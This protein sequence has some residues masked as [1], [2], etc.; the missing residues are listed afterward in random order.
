MVVIAVFSLRGRIPSLSDIGAAMRTADLRWVWVAA[1][2]EAGSM[3]MFARQQRV[4][5]AA[6]DVTMS[7]S[8]AV[9]ITY[10][11]SAIA[12]SMPAGSAVS[13]GFAYRQYR[14]SGATADRAAATMVLSGLVSFFGL[15]ALYGVGGLA[16]LAFTPS[17]TWQGHGPLLL[18][19][20][21]GLLIGGG[22]A[23]AAR[24]R[25]KSHSGTPKAKRRP[26]GVSTA[27][28]SIG[29][30]SRPASTATSPARVTDAGSDSVATAGP[31][32][33]S[34]GGSGCVAT[35]TPVRVMTARVVT[36]KPSAE[37]VAAPVGATARRIAAVRD[38]ASQS[39]TAWHSLRPRHWMAAGLFAVANW[40]LDLLCL[41]ASARAFNLPVG[42]VA[43]A[44]IYV[45]VQ[46]VRQIPLT[47]GGIGLIETGLLAG[48][49]AAHAPAA[50]AAAAV[51]TYRIL[52]CWLII[53]IG[54]LAVLGLRRKA[55]TVA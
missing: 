24:R 54:G 33:L 50:H 14:R 53:P 17:A 23:I 49:A 13:A 38:A 42:L 5:L 55:P 6:L 1:A 3:A 28:A 4:L 40:L 10:A 35:A 22:I 48:L 27:T 16:F 29:M 34:T 20:A 2:A 45:G 9:A 21:A 39:V 12:I 30:L 51:L 36:A 18:T 43:L 52:S 7:L 32:R 41:A 11:R 44:G 47:P 31:A 19:V 8:R 46:L 25:G 15:A 37:P 26:T